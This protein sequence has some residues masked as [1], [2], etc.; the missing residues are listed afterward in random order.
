[1]HNHFNSLFYTHALAGGVML[2]SG[3]GAIAAKKGGKVHR[4]SGKVYAWAT[5]L[6]AVTGFVI[7][8]QKGN[9][10]LLATSI[11]V[12]YMMGTAYRSLYLKQLHK[13]V[14][15]APADWLIM[16]SAAVAALYL[17]YIGIAG[18]FRGNNGGIVPAIFG[19]ICAA[20]IARDVL[21]FTKGPKDKK[22]WLFNHISG[23]VGSYIAGLTAFLAVNA[24][25]FSNNF[26]LSV[27]L[28]PTLL[29]TPYIIYMIRKYKKGKPTINTGGKV[30]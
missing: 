20:F 12:L 8:M 22:H 30:A 11:F 4:T 16:I 1:M 29:G 9:D 17:V 10:F 28:G 21:K 5:A 23:M 15:A 14:R 25:Y 3:M 6:V 24:G 19:G 2:V 7:A 27:W 18:M 13:N 26:L